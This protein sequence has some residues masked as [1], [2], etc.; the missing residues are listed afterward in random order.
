MK[1]YLL[2][3][4]ISFLSTNNFAK[5]KIYVNEYYDI[6]KKYNLSDEYNFQNISSICLEQH[7]TNNTKIYKNDKGQEIL[8]LENEKGFL[9]CTYNEILEIIK[10]IPMVNSLQQKQ[11]EKFITENEITIFRGPDKEK[12]TFVFDNDHYVK[13]VDNKETGRDGWRWGK[14]GKPLRVFING[15]KST[16]KVSADRMALTI[17]IGKEKAIPFFISYENKKVAQSKREELIAK[18]KAREEK[19]KK[20]K[21][22]KE[23]LAK[24]NSL[25]K[26]KL[27][28]LEE[29]IEANAKTQNKLLEITSIKNEM[30]KD[31]SQIN[32]ALDNYNK[33]IDKIT[34]EINESDKIQKL[35]QYK[36]PNE[37]VFKFNEVAN[38]EIN[39]FDD[40]KIE[41]KNFKIEEEKRLAEEERKRA[42]ERKRLA[43]EERIKAEEEKRLALEKE[44][45]YLEEYSNTIDGYKNLKFGNRL[46]NLDGG[47]CNFNDNEYGTTAFLTAM[48]FSP[49][50]LAILGTMSA[51]KIL[52]SEN[53]NKVLGGYPIH[54]IGFDDLNRL[55]SVVLYDVKR[56]NFLNENAQDRFDQIIDQLDTK[57]KYWLPKNF[58]KKQIDL[59]R[60]DY[61]SDFKPALVY[62]FANGEVATILTKDA[63]TGEHILS[64][65]YYSLKSK[66]KENFTN[67]LKEYSAESTGSGL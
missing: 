9:N 59:W 16:W 17:K 52:L 42:E 20:E 58:S 55:T 14:I 51:S 38:N 61:N 13:F 2:I 1:K 24:L 19:A 12:A 4:L 49:T 18:K 11:L 31:I 36:I 40:L 8:E 28:K 53:C 64:V 34:L 67:V 15:K 21:I 65:G 23:K 37:F 54:I 60:S 63:Q 30:G 48:Q 46:S 47:K 32:I 39:N 62:A 25:K 33:E 29:L 43:E 7:K 45:K 56:F 27:K 50:G 3:I 44:K 66:F 41:Y 57:Y 22:A 35:E 6:F 10:P 5:A 26:D